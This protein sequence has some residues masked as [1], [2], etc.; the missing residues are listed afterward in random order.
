MSCPALT[1]DL[2]GEVPRRRAVAS[3]TKV[4]EDVAQHTLNDLLDQERVRRL[5]NGGFR[6]FLCCAVTAP[7]Q[8]SSA[9]RSGRRR[10][11]NCSLRPRRPRSIALRGVITAV[12]KDAYDVARGSRKRASMLVVGPCARCHSGIAPRRFSPRTAS[13]KQRR[14]LSAFRLRPRARAQERDCTSRDGVDG[15]AQRRLSRPSSTIR[16]RTAGLPHRRWR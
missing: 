1:I 8:A 7:S 16:Q 6:E 5:L 14:S 9:S 3:G 12:A 2:D 11:S 15:S 4:A 13:T 10:K